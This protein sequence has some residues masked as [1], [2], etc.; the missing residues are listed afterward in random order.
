MSYRIE[1]LGS[2]L[3]QLRALPRDIQRR[4]ARRIDALAEDPRPTAS[5]L[6]RGSLKGRRRLRVG[7][8]R[9][10]YTVEEDELVVAVISVGHRSVIYDRT[11]RGG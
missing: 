3:K 2:A 5:Q 9:V 1:F 11:R 7:D 10:I 4:I 8:Y 6:L